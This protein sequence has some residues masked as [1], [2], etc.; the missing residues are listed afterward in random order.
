MKYLSGAPLNGRLQ[1][2][3]QTLDYS[4]KAS[5]GQT[6]WLI[7]PFVSYKDSIVL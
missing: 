3:S 2:Y 6:I 4:G 1:P 5:K 7:G